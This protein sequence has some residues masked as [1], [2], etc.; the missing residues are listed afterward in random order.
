[1]SPNALGVKDGLFFAMILEEAVYPISDGY[2]VGPVFYVAVR[3][4]PC[5]DG[6]VVASNLGV[7]VLY[8]FSHGATTV[9]RVMYLYFYVALL[10]CGVVRGLVSSYVS[11]V[12]MEFKYD[13]V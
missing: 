7:D 1:M 3:V 10:H 11:R 6:F 4:V 2:M 9:R 5:V 12:H 13:Y 8:G